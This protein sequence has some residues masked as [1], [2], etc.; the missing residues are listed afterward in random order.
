[1]QKTKV[2]AILSAL[3]SVCLCSSCASAGTS[4]VLPVSYSRFSHLWEKMR[5]SALHEK[6]EEFHLKNNKSH[7]HLCWFLPA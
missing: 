1:M 6:I 2:E 3:N 5:Y 7:L 4:S